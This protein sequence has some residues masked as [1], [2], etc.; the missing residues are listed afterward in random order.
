MI[1]L[2]ERRAEAGGKHGAYLFGNIAGDAVVVK[3]AER[4]RAE[5]LAA[6][7]RRH[8]RRAFARPHLH[9]LFEAAVLADTAACA[10]DDALF[11]RRAVLQ[12]RIVAHDRAAG[13]DAC[14]DDDAVAQHA[15]ADVGA[16]ADA[17]AVADDGVGADDR[18]GFDGEALAHNDRRDDF[19]AHDLRRFR[20]Q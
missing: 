19:C 7:H 17:A 10:D 6:A 16:R 3:Q 8:L 13:S 18:A 20:R 14:A 1:L 12:L 5:H 2:G 9:A 11:Q 4:A 15:V